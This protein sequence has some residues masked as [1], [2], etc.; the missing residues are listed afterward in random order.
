MKMLISPHAILLD[1]NSPNTIIKTKLF[2]RYVHFKFKID[3][4]N[5]K[6][7]ITWLFSKYCNFFF[8]INYII[9]L[10]RILCLFVLDSDFWCLIAKPFYTV[11]TQV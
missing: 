1:I 6:H 11:G 10:L 4:R 8:F 2:V 7:Y 3:Q 5:I 9:R